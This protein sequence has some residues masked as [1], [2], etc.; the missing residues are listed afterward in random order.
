MFISTNT[1]IYLADT[2][3]ER[4]FVY[5]PEA[6]ESQGRVLTFK[7]YYGNASISSF[8][9]ST[10]S[11]NTIDTASNYVDLNQDFQSL[12]L[13]AIG[14]TNWSLTGYYDGGLVRP[15]RSNTLFGISS[16][17]LWLDPTD[18][19][20]MTLSLLNSNDVLQWK[21]KSSNAY[22]FT[23]VNQNFRSQRSTNCITI[24]PSTAHFLSQQPIPGSDEMDV[25]TVIL[26]TSQRGPMTGLF[27]NADCT[28]W[29][30]DGR[31][32]TQIFA[33]GLE[34]N[35]ATIGSAPRNARFCI[36][37]SN[38]YAFSSEAA[39]T[40]FKYTA[41]A[42]SLV[43]TLANQVR[44]ACV[45]DGRMYI[46]TNGAIFAMNPDET[47]VNLGAPA[48]NFYSATVHDY[49]PY[50]HALTNT[51]PLYRYT[52]P[53]NT[54]T[55]LAA[56]NQ[57]EVRS[58]ISYNGTLYLLNRGTGNAMNLLNASSNIIPPGNQFFASYTGGITYSNEIVTNQSG[59]ARILAFNPI[60]GMRF[61]TSN[62]HAQANIWTLMTTY[63]DWLILGT[64]FDNNLRT[65]TYFPGIGKLAPSGS[66]ETF[67]LTTFT[68][69]N[70]TAAI[71]YNGQCFVGGSTANN[72]IYRYGNGTMLDV[73]VSS[74][75]PGVPRLVNLRK[76]TSNV[77]LFVNGS[78]QASQA[79]SF[80]YS[81]NRPQQMY[82]G[83]V[84]GTTN[85]MTSD[86]GRDHMVG[87]LYETL[88]FRRILSDSERQQIEGYLA[89]KYGAQAN[90][91]LGHPYLNSPP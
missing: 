24:A 7:D 27:Q 36:F 61:L 25:Y 64:N 85:N 34:G 72:Q 46:T 67:N 23:P 65:L 37:N 57:S 91:P 14:T 28:F 13:T 88:Q 18:L 31:Y 78:Q 63:R 45:F 33:D 17:S 86:P 54:F 56:T 52:Q 90:L 58:M 75:G 20:T 35:W 2:R 26:D 12:E 62:L 87:A 73:N 48:S 41:G 42:F 60:S 43:S 11:S 32:H 69:S 53:T 59:T 81:N 40:V 1:S 55:L 44:A 89:W 71:T 15:F 30:T 47:F 5:L 22:T 29:E 19:S 16:L 38:L 84:L 83:G 66:T 70:A 8:R 50:F 80:T 49:L 3:T 21:D 68:M 77:A 74:I 51:F 9:I 76:S 4:K 6:S 82:L 79:I 39:N 10:I